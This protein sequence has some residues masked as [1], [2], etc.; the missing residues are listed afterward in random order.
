VKVAGIH[1]RRVDVRHFCSCVQTA[2]RAGRHYGVDLLPE[3]ENPH[4]R[5]AIAVYGH[6]GRASWKIGYLDR[7]TA[8]EITNDVLKKGLTITAELYSIWLGY[9][10]YCDVN[11][12]V[13]APPGHSMSS[14]YRRG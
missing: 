14:R 2:E 13:L 7:D 12:I 1:H 10:G 3:P 8:K 11:V 4:D 6:V 9:D 5:N